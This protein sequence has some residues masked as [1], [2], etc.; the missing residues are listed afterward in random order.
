M[1]SETG[2]YSIRQVADQTGL[3]TQ[4]IRKW[5]Q[6]YQIIE[7]RRLQNGY[8][9]Y[10]A[11]DVQLLSKVQEL[12]QNGY[13]VKNAALAVRSANLPTDDLGAL[14]DFDA[15]VQ[16]PSLQ[17]IVHRLIELGEGSREGEMAALFQR[18]SQQYGITETMHR[19][20][21]PFLRE[22]GR[23]WESGQWSEYQEHIASITVRDFLVQVR[24]ELREQPAWPLLLA[25][26]LPYERHEIPLHML[27][28]ESSLAGW[29]TL[30]L[31]ASPAPG[32]IEEAVL[33]LRPV[34]VALS[35]STWTPFEQD[36][37][38]LSVL[39]EFASMHPS[40]DFYVG[41]DG[42]LSFAQHHRLH[43]IHVATSAEE[44]YRVSRTHSER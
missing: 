28:I 7:P 16:Q 41:G 10:T 24:G 19:I 12:V 39:D 42:A 31:G 22:I 27:L 38:L 5:E 34:R 33:R 20:L 18:C 23:L 43:H 36:D 11:E 1:R 3:T 2:Y 6:R 17:R 32:A 21:T 15:N 25:S 26:C 8:R 29:R 13:S 14:Q 9:V 35:A 44:V 40:V 30:F 37:Q 4:L